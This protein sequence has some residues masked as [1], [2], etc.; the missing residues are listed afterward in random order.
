MFSQPQNYRPKLVPD[1]LVSYAIPYHSRTCPPRKRQRTSVTKRDSHVM[2][3]KRINDSKIQR[4]RKVVRFDISAS[5][6]QAKHSRRR[7]EANN[8]NNFS[9]LD[10]AKNC[11]DRTMLSQEEIKKCWYNRSDLISFRQ[12][13]KQ[14]LYKHSGIGIGTNVRVD[15][16]SLPRGMKSL[17]P[18]RRRHKTYALRYILLAHRTGKDQDYLARLCIKL[19]RWNKEIAHRDACLDFLEIY[20]PSFVQS[21][22]PIMSNPPNIPFV[23]DSVPKANGL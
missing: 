3:Y 4:L 5:G 11:S 12:A 9:I 7:N 15:D 8:N 22:P 1:N 21:V 17:S 20:H 14:A 2:G 16:E 10:N 18:I 6:Q 23:P 19:G 13:I